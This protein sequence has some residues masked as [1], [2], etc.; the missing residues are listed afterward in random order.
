M[1]TITISKGRA[2]FWG[3][4]LLSALLLAIPEA[5]T[6]IPTWSW[7]SIMI[8]LVWVASCQICYWIGCKYGE[9]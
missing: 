3:W 7:Q 6:G 2:L 9:E 5:E 4:I 8:T 1:I